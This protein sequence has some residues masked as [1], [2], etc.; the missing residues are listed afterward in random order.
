MAQ[1]DLVNVKI[2]VIARKEAVMQNALVIAE[3]L[4]VSAKAIATV[5]IKELLLKKQQANQEKEKVIFQGKNAREKLFNI[6][7]SD[8]QSL[9]LEIKKGVLLNEEHLFYFFSLFTQNYAIQLLQN[10]ACC[11]QCQERSNPPVKHFYRLLRSS[12]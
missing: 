9:L 3:T 8:C 6:L 2:M 12:Q 5:L 1:E 7:L 4:Q 11:R 10:F